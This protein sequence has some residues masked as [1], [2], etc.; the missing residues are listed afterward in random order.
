MAMSSRERVLAAVAHRE[1]DRVPVDLGGSIMSG[2][3]AQPL[4]RLR[5]HLGMADRP[6]K[7][8]E[9]YQMLGE[10]EA[11][12]VERL[13]ID[14]LPVEP[15]AIFFGLRREGWKPWRLFDGTAVLV[16]GQFDVEV[17]ASG[18]WLLHK[19]GDPAKPVVGR[20]PKGGY[21]FDTAGDMSLHLDFEP[22][23]LSEVEKGYRQPIPSAR[24]EYLAAEA[25]RL[26]ATG[27]ALFLGAWGS[28]GPPTVGNLPDFLALMAADEAYV[29]R[30]FEIAADSQRSRLEQLHEAVG[31]RIDIFGIDGTDMGTQRAEM[32]RPEHFERWY[33]PYYRAI[34]GWVHGHTSWKT[35]KDS[36]GSIPKFMA[37]LA[38]SGLDCINPVQCSAAGMDPRRLKEE[39]GDRLTFWGGGVDTQKTLPF[40][41]PEQVYDEVAERLRVFGPGGGFVFNPVHNVQANTPPENIEAMFEAIRDH[42]T[43][44]ID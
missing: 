6:V 30:L 29:D 35:W 16:P 38:A 13:G 5:K 39:F 34:N 43:Y 12:L 44:L 9:V 18:D 24:L 33:L 15:P 8:Y 14:V 32:F 26:R 20:M 41:T 36:C 11:D 42:G 23:A 1:A 22:P 21:Y 3:M 25:E 40:G 4:D 17:D 27:K 19:G 31:D 28:F 7:V 37:Y 2:I 10:V